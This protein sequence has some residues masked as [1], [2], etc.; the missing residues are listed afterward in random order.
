MKEILKYLE[1]Y[2]KELILGPLFKL[3]EAIIEISLPIIIA[4]IIDNYISLTTNKVVLYIVGILTLVLI[5]FVS[6]S[7]SQ[8]FAAKA[9]QGYGTN[10][11]RKFFKHI[12]LLSNKQL[13]KYGA[14]ALV[15]RITNDINNLEIAVA[16]FIRLVL[17]S[18]FICIG[19]LI[20]ISIINVRIAIVVTIA[21]MILS[22]SIYAIFKASSKLQQNLN[23]RIDKALVRIKEILVNIRLIR[24]FN[25]KDFEKE[26]FSIENNKIFKISLKYNFISNLLTPTNVMI[27]NIAIVIILYISKVYVKDISIGNLIAIINY[28]SQMTNAVIVLSNLIIIYTRAFS[29]AN[30]IAEI[31]E[32]K[33]DIEYGNITEMNNGENAI[34]FKNISFSYNEESE[35]IKDFNL[36]VKTGEI[37][38]IIG[39]TASGKTSLLNLITRNYEVNKGEILIFD[40]NICDYNKQTLKRNI[41][42]IS[43]KKQFFTGTIEENIS[44][45]ENINKEMLEKALEKSDSLEFVKKMKNKE[46]T[47]LEGN[48]ANLSGGQRQRIAIARAFINKP[49]ILILD[50]ITSSVDVKTE[51]KILN[52]IY[53]F[54]KQNNI[55]TII[56]AQKVSAL[57]MCNKI[58]VMNAGK[59]DNIGNQKELSNSSKIYK[60]IL[61]L[62]HI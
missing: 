21:L 30:R 47:I 35:L 58:I 40:K 25:T 31:M 36:T 37:I 53:S 60:E 45:G 7:I 51:E 56:S 29:S 19:S 22:I 24:S 16:M 4:K 52:S 18:P 10:L 42:I 44:L 55:T 50:D 33:P 8:Y 5:G 39:F 61:D 27:L 48:G 46:Y 41:K 28:I 20:M 26:K 11:R 3:F 15:N 2:K 9:S 38:G 57:K 13:S 1:K 17:R 34:I 12:S 59:I 49:K 43:Q 6:A 23:K 14:S 62:Q 32:I 54:I